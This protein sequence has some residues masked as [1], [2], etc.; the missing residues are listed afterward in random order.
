MA[1]EVDQVTRE[2]WV[3][4]LHER[5]TGPARRA[6]LVYSRG[7]AHAEEAAAEL[8]KR[9]QLEPRADA[10]YYRFDWPR[11]VQLGYRPLHL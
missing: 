4:F 3:A 6:L 9:P 10:K 7:S 11:S 8:E 2:D 1:D 5:L